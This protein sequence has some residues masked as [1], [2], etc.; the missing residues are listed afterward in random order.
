MPGY[1]VV[2]LQGPLNHGEVAP[3]YLL[4]PRTN[5]GIQRVRVCGN[6]ELPLLPGI[7]FPVQR[8]PALGY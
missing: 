8:R 3:L 6:G 7:G 5:T 1:T 2:R 4:V